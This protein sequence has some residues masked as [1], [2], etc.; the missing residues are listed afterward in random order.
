M[1]LKHCQTDRSATFSAKSEE[2]ITGARKMPYSE[3]NK[4]VRFTQKNW[5]SCNNNLLIRTKFGLNFPK[6]IRIT[7]NN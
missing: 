2:I 3:K 1:K 7:R 5:R 4:A 6:N